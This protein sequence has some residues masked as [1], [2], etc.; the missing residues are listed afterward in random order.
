MKAGPEFE[1][2]YEREAQSV[3]GAVFLLCRDATLA[4]DATQEAFARVFARW[5]RLGTQ[6]WAGGWVMTTAL[7]VA[8]RGLRRRHL[9]VEAGPN[10]E[11]STDVDLW[12]V[13]RRLP[14]RQQHTVVLRYR[15]DLP[16]R[17]IAEILGCREGTV[18]THLA[19]ARDSLRSSLGGERDRD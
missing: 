5:D 15:M 10:P 7:N 4:E 12:A 2:F 16:V 1:R 11:H 17:E 18:R 13:V 9:R 19:R 6:P 8:R 3:F 14:R